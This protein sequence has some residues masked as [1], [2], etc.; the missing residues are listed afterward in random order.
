MHNVGYPEQAPPV[1]LTCPL[2]QSSNFDYCIFQ[3]LSLHLLLSIF[4]FLIDTFCVLDV[5]IFSVCFNFLHY[6]SLKYIFIPV[7]LKYLSD[8]SIIVNFL[9]LV[10]I[11]GF[12]LLKLVF[13]CIGFSVIPW[14]FSV[15][16]TIVVWKKVFPHCLHHLNSCSSV[17]GAVWEGSEGMALLEQVCPWGWAL[18]S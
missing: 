13:L 17:S 10:S 1:L 15:F 2:V 3:F 4:S 8:N 16:M 5:S 14:M 18:R 6:C 11:N 7:A 12:F 9:L